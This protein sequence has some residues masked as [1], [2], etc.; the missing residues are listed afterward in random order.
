MPLWLQLKPHLASHETAM[1]AAVLGFVGALVLV[2]ATWRTI[3]LRKAIIELGQIKPLDPNLMTGVTVLLGKLQQE[4]LDELNTEHRLY[5]WGA[6]VL[7]L[8]FIISFVHELA[9]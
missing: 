4:Q 7:A 6:L 5:L 3:K 2:A 9:Y 8:G 1:I